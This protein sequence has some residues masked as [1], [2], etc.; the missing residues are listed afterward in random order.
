MTKSR[1]LIRTKWKPTDEQTAMVRARFATTRTADLAA[2]LGVEPHQVS[3]LASKLGLVKDEAWLNGPSGGRTD[4]SKG[5]GTRFQPG[6]VPWSKG[7]RLPGHGAPQTW[8]KPSHS[9]KT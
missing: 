1:N 5:L 9:P 7:K 2:D 6:L 4:G 8:F 3:K